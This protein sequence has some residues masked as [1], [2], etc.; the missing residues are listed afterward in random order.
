MCIAINVKNRHF[1]LESDSDIAPYTLIQDKT[2][3][4]VPRALHNRMEVGHLR[5]GAYW[6]ARSSQL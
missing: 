4:C 5:T 3:R 2:I 6:D 1:R